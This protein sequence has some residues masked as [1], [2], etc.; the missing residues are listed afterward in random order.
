MSAHEKSAL[1]DKIF[2]NCLDRHAPIEKI[3]I[4]K[5]YKRGLSKETL[6]LIKERDLARIESIR[7]CDVNKHILAIKYRKLRN[8]V[9]AKIKKESKQAV[10]DEMRKNNSPLRFLEYSKI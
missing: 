3:K 10:I 1:F 8:R 9:I 2:E 5:N 4:H 6:A 7:A